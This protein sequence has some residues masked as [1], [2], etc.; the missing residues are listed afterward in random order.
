MHAQSARVF[1]LFSFLFA[2]CSL[3][4]ALYACPMCSDIVGRGKDALAAMRFGSGIGWSIVFMLG[5]LFSMI[6]AFVFAIWKGQQ[7]NA[8]ERQERMAGGI[9]R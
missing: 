5:I 4:S 3:P 2:L 7:K 6:G 9:K 1:F 8:R